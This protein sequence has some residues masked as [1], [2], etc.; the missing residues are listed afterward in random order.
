MMHDTSP[1]SPSK[2]LLEFQCSLLQG[3][4]CLLTVSTYQYHLEKFP[5]IQSTHWN[6]QRPLEH[7]SKLLIQPFLGYLVQES[8]MMFFII[9]TID[10]RPKHQ[11]NLEFTL[12]HFFPRY[13]C[14]TLH[15]LFSNKA[16]WSCRI[17]CVH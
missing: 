4:V 17:C 16:H 15:P 14:N 12:L 9:L 5:I 3:Y 11:F 13:K 7:F 6:W 8:N 10:N 2:S 1:T